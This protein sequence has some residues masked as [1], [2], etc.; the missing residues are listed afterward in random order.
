MMQQPLSDDLRR[1]NSI[2]NTTASLFVAVVA[3][4]IDIGQELS[5]GFMSAAHK[6]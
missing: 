4:L 3:S 6:I 5:D 2:G 1:S